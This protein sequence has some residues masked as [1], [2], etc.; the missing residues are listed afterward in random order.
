MLKSCKIHMG[1]INEAVVEGSAFVCCISI[2]GYGMR[3]LV[4][5]ANV[6]SVQGTL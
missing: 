5:R 1:Q 6:F 3:D 2:F 4:T